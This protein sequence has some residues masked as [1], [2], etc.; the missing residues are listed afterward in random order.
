[1]ESVLA[2]GPVA[3][4]VPARQALALATI[5][6]LLD[7]WLKQIGAVSGRDPATLLARDITLD[8]AMN[9]VDASF[10]DR[11][12]SPFRREQPSPAHA[13]SGHRP[14]GGGGGI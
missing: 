10:S 2:R 8:K 11:C 14:F 13:G 7:D 6:F 5:R 12:L 1:M 3:D 4:A 9:R